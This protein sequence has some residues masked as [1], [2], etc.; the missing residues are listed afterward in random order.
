M[1]CLAAR[2]FGHFCC[3]YLA[4]MKLRRFSAQN[5]G[6]VIRFVHWR[7]ETQVSL[8]WPPK[9]L[10]PARCALLPLAERSSIRSAVAAVSYICRSLAL[11]L[12]HISQDAS[13]LLLS[14]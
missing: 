9:P 10:Q 14:G 13:W 6:E 3:N 1:A 12:R 8:S 2:I 11:G 4:G 7:T 5:Y